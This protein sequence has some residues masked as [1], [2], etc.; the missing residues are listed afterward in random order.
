[1]TRGLVEAATALPPIP[2]VSARAS[3]PSSP[4]PLIEPVREVP[5]PTVAIEA[6]PR[7]RSPRTKPTPP[8]P[9]TIVA[10]PVAEARPKPSEVKNP[11]AS[12]G[13]PG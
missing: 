12:P 7:G 4:P 9:A 13:D 2:P 11:F 10:P 1:L 5:T 3:A 6:R 8:A